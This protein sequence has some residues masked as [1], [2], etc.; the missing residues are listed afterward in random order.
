M[1]GGG[2]WPPHF[3]LAAKP[4]IRPGHSPS[5]DGRLST[6]YSPSKD[7]R[8]STPYGPATFS[9]RE[10]GGARRPRCVNA[11][12][13]GY[14][15][16]LYRRMTHTIREK[17]KL[18]ARVRRIRGQVEA[19]ERALEERG[20]LRAGHA[21]HRRRARRDGGPDGR[22]GRGSRAHPSRRRRASSRR[23]ERRSGRPAC[24][25]SSAPISK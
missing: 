14:G 4:L 12:G 9:R 5:K 1:R 23:A 19:I 18:L 6:P 22:G 2:D 20:R 21:S 13:I 24:S 25:T 16:M 17:Q 10:K 7:G 11:V 15:G 3:E 8:L